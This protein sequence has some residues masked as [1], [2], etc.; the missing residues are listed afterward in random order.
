M[1]KS[2]SCPL[3]GQ[4]HP[5]EILDRFDVND[6]C[7]EYRR[8]LRVEVRPEFPPDLIHLDLCAC[9]NCGLQFFTPL[10]AGSTGFYASL[11][12]DV[13]YY[14]P[15]RWEFGRALSLVQAGDRVLDLGCGDGR[16]LGMLEPGQGS[17][18]ELNPDAVARARSKGLEVRHGSIQEVESASADVLTM[19][20]VLEHVTNPVLLLREADRVLRPNG[21][22]CVAVPNN[23]AFVGEGLHDPLNSPP[24]HPLRWTKSAVRYAGQM[25][26]FGTDTI[27][28]EPLG[29]E[30][31]FQYRKW[32]LLRRLQ[33]L[34]GWPLKR[35]RRNVSSILLRKCTHAMVMASIWWNPRMPAGPTAGHS[36]LAVFRKR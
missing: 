15:T 32:R 29:P 28:E 19:F 27:E 24:H 23:D 7:A 2:Q 12:R 18:V 16:F 3:C 5:Q 21:R 34:T 31:L 9:P 35:M 8:Q 22:L 25:L 14:A 36:I 33:R 6:L 17:G 20:Q 30:H 10:V 26:S 11:G 4:C 13:A 1:S